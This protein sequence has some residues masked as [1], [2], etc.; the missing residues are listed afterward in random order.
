LSSH[1]NWEACLGAFDPILKTGG[2][3]RFLKIFIDTISRE[4]HKTIFS[5]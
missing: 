5:G 1:L 4:E 2:K 3:A